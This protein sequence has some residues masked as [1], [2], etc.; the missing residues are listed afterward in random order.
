[1]KNNYLKFCI[2]F[3]IIILCFFFFFLDFKEFFTLKYIKIKQLELEDIYNKNS[4]L[5]SFIYV[6]T[7]LLTTLLFLPTATVLT[8]LGGAIFGFPLGIL[9]ISFTSSIGATLS[10]LMS[11]FLMYDLVKERFNVQVKKINYYFE[12]EGLLYLFALRL[13]P[14][15]PFFV[16]NVAMSLTPIK[17]WSYYWISQLSMLP[18]TIIYIYAGTE[19]AKINSID[20]IFEPSM[21][22]SF[23]L[24]GIFPIITKRIYKYV[25]KE[26]FNQ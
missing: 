1:M 2:V 12:E 16:V 9:I 10:F 21:I 19:L 23:V 6:S 7:Y 25:F 13:V 17:I 3:A 20:D 15:F 4:L 18:A 14:L 26:K 24:I 5:V 22:F 8:L 11:R